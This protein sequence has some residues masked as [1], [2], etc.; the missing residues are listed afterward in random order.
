MQGLSEHCG[1]EVVRLFGAA[2]PCS[3]TK[4]KMSYSKTRSSTAVVERAG[5]RW[6]SV[7][8]LD[9]DRA[10][11]VEDGCPNEVCVLGDWLIPGCSADQRGEP[12]L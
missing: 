9:G 1:L 2:E 7:V 12:R 11:L 3:S 6:V 4:V 5:R 10:V 8:R